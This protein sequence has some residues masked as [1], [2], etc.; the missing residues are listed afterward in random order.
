MRAFT[1]GARLDG[2]GI[3]L[4]LCALSFPLACSEDKPPAETAPGAEA[5][6]AT[7]ERQAAPAVDPHARSVELFRQGREDRIRKNWITLTGLH[8]LREGD[9]PFGSAPDNAIVF[10]A[11]TG[12][13]VAGS[14]V[15]E[16][17][18]IFLA[19][20][21]PGLTLNGSAPPEG[22]TRLEPDGDRIALGR[23]EILPIARYGGHAIRVRD[24]EASAARDFKG[25][26][27]YPVDA[28]Y[29]FTGTLIPEDNGAMTT[30]ETVVGRDAE[31]VSRGTI[32]FELESKTYRLAALGAEADLFVMFKDATTGKETYPAGRYL[33]APVAGT[34]VTLDFNMAFNPPCAFTPYATCPLPP[35]GN[36]IDV[37]IEAGE[38]GPGAKH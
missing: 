12:D 36:T 21:A 10:P 35:P 6:G 4:A 18:E 20:P 37:P 16:N 24:P 1:K 33:Y 19:D 9:N 11:D 14:F 32:E 3:I 8:W 29:V 7:S 26:E 23:L 30:V 2:F 38:R 31:M 27:F 34:E 28:A 22:Q 13:A 17:G 5:S 15:Y 25:L